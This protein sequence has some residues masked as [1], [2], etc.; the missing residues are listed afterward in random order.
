[1]LLAKLNY[2]IH[3]KKLLAIVT[4]FQKWRVYLKKSKYQIKVLTN[5]KNLTYFTTTKALNRKQVR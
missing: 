1:M 2:D 3:D 5:Y 4:A